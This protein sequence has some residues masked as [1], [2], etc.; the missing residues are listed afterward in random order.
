MRKTTKVLGTLLLVA[1]GLRVISVRAADLPAGPI[2]ERH[3][4]MEGIGKNAKI[5]GDALEAGGQTELGNAKIVDAA[6]K[7]MNSAS[8]IPGLF[9][10]GSTNPK[11]RAKP[12]IWANWPKFEENAKRLADTAGVTADRARSGGDIKAAADQMFAACKSCHDEFR[13]PKKKQKD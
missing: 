3:E 4:L 13:T 5:I 12:T 7:I 10:Q 11:S 2:R 9:P 8:K 6:L 1:S